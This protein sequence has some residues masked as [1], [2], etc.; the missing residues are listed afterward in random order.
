VHGAF[1]SVARQQR[2]A[3]ELFAAGTV[4]PG[5]FVTARYPL[6]RI[7]EAFAASEAKTG[8]RVVVTME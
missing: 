2:R 1:G 3:L 4:D 6:D 7:H 8:Y 5:K